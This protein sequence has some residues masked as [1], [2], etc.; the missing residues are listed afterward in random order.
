M[1]QQMGG[2]DACCD[3][4][5]CT[6]G[7]CYAAADLQFCGGAFPE[8]NVCSA[9]ACVSDADCTASSPSSLCAPAGAFGQPKRFCLTAY[10][11]TDADCTAE[12]G[13]LCR[14][15]GGDPCCSHPAP[16]GLGCVYPGGCAVDADCPNE[17]TCNLD[18]TR[19]GTCGAPDVGCPP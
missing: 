3:S 10:C 19:V 18:A 5:E 4:T 12:A 13:G 2:G 9:D 14:L 17:G 6:G 15:V 11:K 8:F 16:D 7:S 1:C